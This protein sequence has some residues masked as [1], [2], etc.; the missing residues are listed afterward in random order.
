MAYNKQYATAYIIYMM[1]GS[2][3]KSARFRNPVIEGKL[4]LEYAEMKSADQIKVEEGVIDQ[5]PRLDVPE[6]DDSEIRLGNDNNNML[7]TFDSPSG[8][9]EASI[10]PDGRYRLSALHA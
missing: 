10:A 4:R 5:I 8:R 2:E 1:V 3:Y 6:N 9:I 7:L